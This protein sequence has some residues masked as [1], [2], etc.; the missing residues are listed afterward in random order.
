MRIFNVLIV[1]IYLFTINH[2][3]ADGLVVD[4]VYHPYVTA[5]EQSVEWR[6]L[7]SETSHQ[8]R[9][10]QRLGYGFSLADNMTLESYLIAE[11]NQN[12]DFELQAF[13]TELRW[14]LTEQGQY[15]ADWG[16]L[17]EV[18]LADRN[19][20]R[21]YEVT[22]GVMFEKEFDKTSLTVNAFIVQEWGQTVPTEIEFELRGQYRYRFRPEIQPAIELYTGE[23]F[24]G[25]GPAIIGLKRFD[26][27]KQLKWEVGFISE[28]AHDG[29]DHS[30][31]LALEFEF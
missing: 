15:W 21:N 11:R 13:E 27:K 22:S 8:N 9:L 5:G 3:C 29:K 31:R 19:G 10:G 4:K 25:I 28:I 26:G 1:A 16:L 6:L 17:F 7:S 30:L 24:V 18:E 14:M 23:N 2:A 12:Q 20:G